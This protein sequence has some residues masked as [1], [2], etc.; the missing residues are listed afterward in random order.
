[1][2]SLSTGDRPVVTV[3]ILL[4]GGTTASGKSELAL[5]F[6][7]R[8]GALVVNADAQQLYRDLPILTAAPGPAD[9]A[10]AE[11]RLYRILG[12][13]AATSAGDWLE[14]LRPVLAEAEAR[15]RP[16]CLVGGTGLYMK[17]LL[18]GLAPVPP[19]PAAIREELRNC[20]LDTAALYARLAARDPAM[21]ARLRPG[22][23]QRILRALEVVEAT[24]RS[25]L[26]FRRATRP[27][28]DLRGPVFGVAL[29]PPRQPLRRRIAARFARMLEA[30]VLDEVR[31]LAGRVPHLDTLPI[32]R[33]HGAR[34]LL[35]VLRAEWRLPEAAARIVTVT[36][37]YAK[38]QRTF[39]R[40]Q[41]PGF[42]PIEAFGE[43]LGDPAE[44][45][46]AEL[47]TG[48]GAATEHAPSAAT[49]PSGS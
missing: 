30:G 21:A 4:I 47:A 8:T 45:F 12:P 42:R 20:R 5:R 22:D 38:R 6:A 41:L 13:D 9:L 25:L 28:F 46:A 7:E 49:V 27:A 16:V 18:E 24:G 34:E 33:L 29:L 37:R 43:E 32:A 48:R 10:R 14:R 2:R 3:P 36:A 35:R 40:T 15:G 26:E 44:A 19:V 39:F 17:A 1:M 31:D 11:H 23:R